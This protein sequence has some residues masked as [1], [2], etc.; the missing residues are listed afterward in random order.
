MPAKG[1]GRSSAHPRLT[2]LTTHDDGVRRCPWDSAVGSSADDVARS[3]LGDGALG[4]ALNPDV[5][6]T[7]DRHVG[8]LAGIGF[9]IARSGNRHIGCPGG[10][11]AGA[12]VARAGD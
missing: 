3:R 5:A 7:H 11:A 9:D 1:S 10:E 12:H 6:R 8:A 4:A 2:W